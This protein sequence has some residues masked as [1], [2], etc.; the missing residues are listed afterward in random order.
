MLAEQL[1]AV[2][3]LQL[4]EL[5]LQ[6]SSLHQSSHDSKCADPHLKDD[7][8]ADAVVRCKPGSLAG[9]QAVHEVITSSDPSLTVKLFAELAAG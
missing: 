7:K 8:D 1:V 3:L 2:L 9:P 4:S 6:L 5:P